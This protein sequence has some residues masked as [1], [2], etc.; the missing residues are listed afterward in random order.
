MII[1]GKSAGRFV[2]FILLINPD[3]ICAQQTSKI[4]DKKSELTELKNEIRQLESEFKAKVRVEKKSIELIENYNRQNLILNKMINSIGAEETVMQEEIKLTE[5]KI[6]DIETVIRKLKDNYTRYIIYLYKYGRNDDLK[7][8]LDAGSINKALIR[9]KYLQRLSVRRQRDIGELKKNETELSRLQTY[10]IDKKDEK[11]LIGEEKRDEEK[12]L[13][14]KLAERKKIL[15]LL[16]NDKAS[17]KKELELKKRSE[18]EI[19]NWIARLI[20]EDRRKEKARR[21]QEENAKNQKAV[22]MNK[23][24]DIIRKETESVSEETKPKEILESLSIRHGVLRWPVDNGK[25]IRKFGENRNA[26][27][28]TV[29]LNYGIDIR[30]NNDAG[31]KAAAEGIVSTVNW[32]PGYGSILIIS[33]KNNLRTVYGHLGEI[34]VSE[35]SKILSGAS[36]GKVGESLEGSILHFEVW[37]ERRNQNPEVW[38]GKK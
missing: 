14:A 6:T 7:A 28:N 35:G 29:T 27:L 17:L 23:K 15:G 22:V 32:L 2:L 5:V 33:H 37:D 12:I 26:K 38:L 16:R 3:I 36:I 21:I 30:T 1:S 9:Y 25:V 18:G 4:N 10:L 31:V 34:Y 24:S 19:R 13:Q 8:I 11:H 20:E